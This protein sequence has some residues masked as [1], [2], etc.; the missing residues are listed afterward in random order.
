MTLR[1]GLNTGFKEFGTVG[2]ELEPEA[3]KPWMRKHVGTGM[4]EGAEGPGVQL[5]HEGRT[6]ARDQRMIEEDFGASW[7]NEQT[8]GTS[9]MHEERNFLLLCFFSIAA[10]PQPWS[11][12]STQAVPDSILSVESS[13][14]SPSTIPCN[15]TSPEAQ[16][17][18]KDYEGANAGFRPD[19][20]KNDLGTREVV[21]VMDAHKMLSDGI[22]RGEVRELALS[23]ITIMIRIGVFLGSVSAMAAQDVAPTVS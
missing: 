19:V 5:V 23:P 18:M 17:R 15:L 4:L 2:R 21:Q 6:C 11:S 1:R 20:R 16:R 12:T 13:S 10:T 3:G 8:N 22:C 14:L 7:S 9:T